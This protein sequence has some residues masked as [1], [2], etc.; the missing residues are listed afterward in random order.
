MAT[1]T[2]N[3]HANAKGGKFKGCV[4]IGDGRRLQPPAS[5]RMYWLTFAGTVSHVEHAPQRDLRAPAPSSRRRPPLSIVPPAH[6]DPHPPAR[7]IIVCSDARR[8]VSHAVQFLNAH[9]AAVYALLQVVN[10][11]LRTL[12]AD[13]TGA[14]HANRPTKA[15]TSATQSFTPATMCITAPEMFRVALDEATFRVGPAR[16][17]TGLGH[18]TR[19]KDLIRPK[20]VVAL[21]R[22]TP[23]PQSADEVWSMRAKFTFEGLPFESQD[24]SH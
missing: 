4:I 5:R 22:V 15:F 8:P 18:L 9:V 24:R 13:S 1:M 20:A 23:I 11:A 21:E 6:Q 7:E 19:A 3:G 16:A 2:K 12:A 17:A 10:S 14:T